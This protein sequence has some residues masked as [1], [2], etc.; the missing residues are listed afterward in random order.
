MKH[1]NTV[2]KAYNAD[3]Q[4]KAAEPGRVDF[5]KRVVDTLINLFTNLLGKPFQGKMLDLGC[6]DGSVVRAL[7]D[8]GVISA[9]GV[10]IHQGLDFETDALKFADAAF[11][12]VLMY[13]VIEHLHN[14]G[15][16]LSE[17]RRVLKKGGQLIVITPNF[18]LT[19]FLI[20][21]RTFYEDPTHVHPY[22]PV[23][24]EH[25][26]KIYGFKKLFLGLWTVKKSA[27][28][29]KLPS[30][31]QFYVGALLPFR[32][33]HPWAPGFLKGQSRTILSVFENAG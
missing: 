20:C 10:D 3:W 31:L 13:S 4:Q 24:L 11:D 27:A 8:S 33:N 32:G 25:V 15:N 12:L 30:R 29:W 9:E 14:P 16:A 2:T 7:N 21:D 6:G 28:F 22:N 1:R 17:V 23:S 18:D 26:M 19:S 5:Q